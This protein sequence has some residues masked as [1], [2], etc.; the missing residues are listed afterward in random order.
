MYR[1]QMQNNKCEP[2]YA[3]QVL[4][5]RKQFKYVKLNKV[6][7][8]IFICNISINYLNILFLSAVQ[9]KKQEKGDIRE[10]D[11]VI[12]QYKNGLTGIGTVASFNKGL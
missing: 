5:T 10:L 12:C 8:K 7:N 4:L 6:F 3:L 1:I 11:A 9:L 2:Y